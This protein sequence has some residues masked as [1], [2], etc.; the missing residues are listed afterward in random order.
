MTEA[1]KQLHSVGPDQRPLRL[2]LLR[3]AQTI[4]GFFERL[5]EDTPRPSVVK[6]RA[7]A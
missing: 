4:D 6:P 2:R 1:G 3:S 7:S 5:M